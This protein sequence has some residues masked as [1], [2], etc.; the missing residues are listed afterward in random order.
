MTLS[1]TFDQLDWDKIAAFVEQK[2]EENLHLDFKLVTNSE[3]TNKDDKRNFARSL[4]GFANSSGG[5][6][7]WGIDARK[8]ED[9]IDCATAIVELTKPALMVTRLNTMTGDA[10]SPIVDGVRHKAIINP[11]TIGR[12]V[13]ATL[14]PESDAGPFMAKLGEQRYYKRS[15]DSFYPMEHFDLEDMFGRRQKPRLVVIVEPVKIENGVEDYKIL[16]LNQG[17]AVARHAGFLL[18]FGNVEIKAVDSDLQNHSGINS[19]RPVVGWDNQIGVIHPNGIRVNIGGVSLSRL[20]AHKNIRLDGTIY[21]E[22]AA[23]AKIALEFGPPVA[24][25]PSSIESQS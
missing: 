14:V 23:A 11:N 12:G 25:D 21:C 5:I 13:V 24:T 6:I 19:G 17:R 4:S 15:G 2:Q 10:S 20:D 9:G 16:V 3:L 22:G 8:N 18:T 7:I 1:E